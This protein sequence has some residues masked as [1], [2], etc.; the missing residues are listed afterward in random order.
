MLEKQTIL[1]EKVKLSPQSRAA[2]SESIGRGFSRPP[3]VLSGC[4]WALKLKRLG[5]EPQAHLKRKY[6][7]VPT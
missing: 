1:Q 2:D 6:Y 5:F 7:G 3:R 4:Q